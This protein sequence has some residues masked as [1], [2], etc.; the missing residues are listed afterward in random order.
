M[1]AIQIYTIF[2]MTWGLLHRTQPTQTA[3]LADTRPMLTSLIACLVAGHGSLAGICGGVRSVA[4][5]NVDENRSV[6]GS[7]Q[8]QNF[9][10]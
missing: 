3:E 5:L 10:K 7:S 8:M 2:Y 9:F 1:G 6:G 4:G